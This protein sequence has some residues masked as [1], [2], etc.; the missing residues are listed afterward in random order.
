[1]IANQHVL[2]IGF[3]WPEPNSSAAGG[4]ML[5]L[6][7]VF[8]KMGLEVTFAS[9]AMDS[10]Y[11]IDLNSLG[12]SKKSIAL[13]C[14]SFDDY[15]KDLNP[16]IV[17]FDRFMM[18]EQ[19]G[20][21]VAENC[22]DTLRLLDTEDLHCLRLARQKAFKENRYFSTD[23]LLVEE[24]AKREIASI[25]RSDISLMI[26]EFEME[27]LQSVFKIDS[28]LL[29]YLPLL[30]DPIEES[31]IQNLP[32]FEERNNFVFIGNF[33][34]EPN[35]N[36]VQY[37]KETIWPLIRKQMPEAVLQIYGA[38]PSQKVLLLHQPK[39]G[40]YIMGRANDA[41][42]FVKNARVVLAPLR[43]G[44]GIKGKLVEAMQ[45]GT[46][47]VTTTIGAESMCGVLPWN[48]F[49]TDDSQVFADKAVQL[50]QD[51]TL[52]RKAQENGFEIIEK[53]YLKSLFVDDFM[54]HVLKV[55]TDLK[56]HRLDNF[57]G[58]LLQHHTLTSTKYMSRWIQEKNKRI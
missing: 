42:E 32:S 39:D 2:I 33:L 51:K 57:M 54:L 14:S 36:A 38:Y 16:A 43:F 22:P 1:M 20:W 50:Y 25:L 34:H 8:K 17:L 53:R 21:R 11:M 45:C 6:I 24:V 46:P 27:L 30:L 28:S 35:W 31:T 3:V 44:A 13:N 15:A 55:Q 12:V 18:E 48:G 40:F 23:D 37:L 9:P 47:S 7:A 10:D 52:W 56:L 26:A 29:F 5:Q 49:I 41:Q 58:T 19:F 4:R